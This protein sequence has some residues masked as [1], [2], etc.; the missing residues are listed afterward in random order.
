M[1]PDAPGCMV[2]TA[3]LDPSGTSRRLVAPRA[4]GMIGP[5][6]KFKDAGSWIAGPMD[7]RLS[8]QVARASAPQIAVTPR[9]AIC[10]S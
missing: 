10:T 2:G 7:H 6:A 8:L 9:P 1:T 4:A 5:L 3:A